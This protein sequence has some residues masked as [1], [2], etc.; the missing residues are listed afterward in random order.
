VK[1]M[2]KQ[3][4][5]AIKTCPLC[6]GTG[7]YRMTRSRKWK[8]LFFVHNYSCRAC[9]SQ[10]VRLFGL[11]SLLVERGFKPFYIPESESDSAVYPG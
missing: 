5:M 11:F 6:G 2:K 7:R 3:F 8:L 1:E 4:K 10:Y 9:H